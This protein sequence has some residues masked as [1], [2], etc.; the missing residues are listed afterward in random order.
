[1]K[2]KQLL[3]ILIVMLGFALGVLHAQSKSYFL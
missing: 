2:S 3:T 1:M